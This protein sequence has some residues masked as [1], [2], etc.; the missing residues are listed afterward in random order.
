MKEPAIASTIFLKTPERI[1]ALIML[2]NVSLLIRAL[3]QY[4]I[5]KNINDSKEEIPRIGWDKK[6]LEKLTIKFVLEAL[7]S[8]RLT[9][10]GEN[11]YK[12]DLYD[13]IDTLR[14]ITFLKLL[15]ISI[16]EFFRIILLD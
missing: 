9:R 12:C 16:E 3:I 4:K 14:I 2:L 8:A 7:Q 11:C 5:R 10:T 13:D 1:N 15:D 6:K